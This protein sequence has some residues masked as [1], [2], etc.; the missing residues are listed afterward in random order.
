MLYQNKKQQVLEEI[1]TDQVR[2]TIQKAVQEGQRT[3]REGYLHRI[4]TSGPEFIVACEVADN[5]GL[6]VTV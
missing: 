2:Y 1:L 5:S 4:S 6:E 3:I